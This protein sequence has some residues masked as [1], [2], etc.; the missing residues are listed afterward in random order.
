MYFSILLLL[1]NTVIIGGLAASQDCNVLAEIFK[2]YGLETYWELGTNECCNAYKDFEY[3]III[4]CN[5]DNQIIKVH[6]ADLYLENKPISQ[7]FCSLNSLISLELMNNGFSGT[8]PAC[9]TSLTTL[10]Y[11]NLN[12]NDISGSI[13]SDIGKLTNLKELQLSKNSFSGTLP[14]SLGKLKSLTVLYV[15]AN[16]LEGSIPNS[17][18]Y[19][20]N[21]KSLDLSKNGFS[22]N[23]PSSL[24]SLT[25]LEHL[26]LNNNEFSGSISEDIGVFAA[27]TELDLKN[28]DFKG[29]IPSSI[30]FLQNLEWLSLA[31]NYLSGEFPSI[32]KLKYLIYL[33]VSNND[34]RSMPTSLKALPY[35]ASINVT[36]NNNLVGELNLGKEAEECLMDTSKVCVRGGSC[37][38]NIKQCTGNVEENPTDTTKNNNNSSN[39]SSNEINTDDDSCWAFI[40]GYPCCK[41]KSRNHV[42]AEDADGEWGYDINKKSW[43]GISSYE[44]IRNKYTKGKESDDC[45]S[46]KY[47]YSCC[48]GCTN[49]A[50]T[51]EGS[52]GIE[53]DNWC[54]IPSYCKQ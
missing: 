12:D 48:I 35:L 44:E 38:G 54:G 34:I 22:G 4:N 29:A 3:P 28:N 43:C 37:K 16:D 10:E 51:E 5:Q 8:M 41:G 1:L 31:N 21:I 33:D 7:K 30:N 17:F 19:L 24:F 45:W 23:L 49:F 40:Y 26:Y 53:R 11:L 14:E 15:D 13:L 47:G 36:K 6:M 20:D 2:E 27:L 46:T 18:A 39:N 52:W 42:Y 32:E 25:T 9:L 50:T